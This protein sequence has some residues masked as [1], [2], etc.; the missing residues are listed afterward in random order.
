MAVI[1]RADVKMD[2]SLPGLSRWNMVNAAAGAGHLEVGELAIAPGEQVRLHIHETHEEAMYILDGPMNYVLGDES[3]V[4]E[5]GDMMLAPAAVKHSLQNPGDEP[6]R[7]LFIFPTT[8]VQRTY[9]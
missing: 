2:E 9:L 3:G 5:A 4:L 6:R 8:N 1:R 7:L